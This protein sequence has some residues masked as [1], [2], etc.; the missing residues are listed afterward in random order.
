MRMKTFLACLLVLSVS[1]EVSNAACYFEL[2]K[3]VNPGDEIK[4]CYDSKGELHEFGSQWK[5]VDCF[6]CSCS[7][8]G[9][10]CCTIYSTPVGYDKE[11]CVSIFN[12]ETCTYEVVEKND[13]SKT[14]PVHEMVG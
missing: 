3:P 12:K 10:D 6:E 8:E 4:G 9:I 5:T 2:L 11:K 7:R 1:V 14:C 13:H